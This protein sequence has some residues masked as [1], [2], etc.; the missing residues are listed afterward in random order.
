MKT[1]NEIYE[2]YRGE[3]KAPDRR[4]TPFYDLEDV[5]PD[6][7]SPNGFRY[8]GGYH[9]SDRDAYNLI[10]KAHNNPNMQ[11][12]IYRA[13][14]LGLDNPQINPGDWVAITRGYARDHGKAVFDKHTLLIKTVRA[15]DLWNDGNSI[16][17]YGYD[18]I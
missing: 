13:I 15:K 11:I 9:F 4:D 3:H 18:P 17:E 2:D 12:K 8:Y 1:F 10:R 7:Y 16:Q 6:I 5:M 14:P